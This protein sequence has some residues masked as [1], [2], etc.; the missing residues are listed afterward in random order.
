LKLIILLVGVFIIILGIVML[1]TPGQGIATI[2]I[3]L[4]ILATE[5]T[6]AKKLKIIIKKNLKNKTKIIKSYFR[7]RNDKET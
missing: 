2:I 1:F 3:G 4:S 5:F 6:W 7:E